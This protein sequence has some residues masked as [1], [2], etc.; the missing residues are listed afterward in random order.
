MVKTQLDIVRGKL[1][2]YRNL[3]IWKLAVELTV[4]VYRLVENFPSHEKFGLSSQLSRSVNSV[5]ANIAESCG[6]YH[7]KDKI[8]FL[9]HS[10]GSLIETEHH[11]IIANKLKFITD[12]E[13]DDMMLKIK[14]IAI[15]LNN[16]INSLK[17]KEVAKK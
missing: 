10:R 16:Y 1:D 7:F 13:L 5:G 9:Y 11:L 3:E 6:R 2:N 8:N 15:K 4:D 12:S 17:S 14:K